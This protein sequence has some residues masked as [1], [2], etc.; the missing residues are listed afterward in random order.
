MYVV[1]S[2]GSETSFR[3]SLRWPIHIINPVDKTKLSGSETGWQVTSLR[4]IEKRNIKGFFHSV[5]TLSESAVCFPLAVKP[6]T[7]IS[8]A[9]FVNLCSSFSLAFLFCFPLSSLSSK[10]SSSSLLFLAAFCSFSCHVLSFLLKC[11][12][13]QFFNTILP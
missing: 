3:I 4:Q 13:P 9:S 12:T 2:T 8:G 6:N 10:I 11:S 1:N 7:A 5:L